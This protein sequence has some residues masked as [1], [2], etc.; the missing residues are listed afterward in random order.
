MSKGN[1]RPLWKDLTVSS[2]R[3][4]FVREHELRDLVEDLVT[5]LDTLE[6]YPACEGYT[7]IIKPHDRF[8]IEH[9]LEAAAAYLDTL[10]LRGTAP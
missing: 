3:L 8:C 7:K 10:R 4:N 2:D 5:A 1:P 9:A 6:F